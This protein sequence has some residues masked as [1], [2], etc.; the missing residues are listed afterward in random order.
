MP[1]SPKNPRPRNPWV[2]L[3]HHED[4]HKA[5]NI[6]NEKDNDDAEKVYGKLSSSWV[7]GQKLAA[8]QYIKVDVGHVQY[9]DTPQQ[10]G[11]YE[12]EEETAGHVVFHGYTGDPDVSI[13][14]ERES[15][16]WKNG[17]RRKQSNT[18][19]GCQ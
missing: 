8:D 3:G 10:W 9:W 17:Q 11:I 16:G 1:M 14:T 18:N 7:L 13:S 4:K 2:G 19:V 15:T 6:P 12:I 5:R